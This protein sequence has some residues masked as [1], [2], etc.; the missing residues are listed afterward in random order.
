MHRTK[1]ASVTAVLRHAGLEV[2]IN[3]GECIT[4][5]VDDEMTMHDDDDVARERDSL[6]DD[7][8][9]KALHVRKS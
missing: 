6:S 5:D 7:G 4:D 8:V 2:A 9:F 3:V 1:K